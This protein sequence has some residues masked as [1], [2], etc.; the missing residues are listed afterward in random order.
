MFL[1]ASIQHLLR[2]SVTWKSACANFHFIKIV[3]ALSTGLAERRGKIASLRC[4]QHLR[5]KGSDL[6][7]TCTLLSEPRFSH[8]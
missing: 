3:L 1:L 2:G 7:S 4:R 5:K 6:Q 8:G